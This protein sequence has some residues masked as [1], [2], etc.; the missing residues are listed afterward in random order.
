MSVKVLTHVLEHSQHSG[1][2]LLT[3]IIL[4]DHADE[5]GICWP[6]MDRVG[7]LIRADE[8]TA[9][10]CVKRLEESGELRVERGRGRGK[11]N[12]YQIPIQRTLELFEEKGGNLSGDSLPPIKKGT[13]QTVKPDTAVSAEPSGT[14]SRKPS[15][16]PSPVAVAFKDYADGIRRRYRV[17]YP[18][19]AQANGLLAGIVRELGADGARRAIAHY[20]SRTDEFYV[21]NRHSLKIL[22][23]DAGAIYIQAQ[24]QAGTSGRP[25]CAYCQ[26]PAVGR[27]NGTDHCRAHANDAMDRKAVPEPEHA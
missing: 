21:R 24:E 27:V 23:R 10:R 5:N 9:R 13:N 11:V 17:E 26:S 14:V 16:G 18:P 12:R 1:N 6:S 3:L 2:E 4:A 19:S 22:K 25:R 8:R 7:K 15:T 20:L